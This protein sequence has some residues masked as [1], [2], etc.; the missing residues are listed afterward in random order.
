MVRS[1]I[2][3]SPHIFILI[4]SSQKFNFYYLY[5]SKSTYK[6]K[7]KKFYDE[8]N[9]SHY[10]EH[11]VITNMKFSSYHIHMCCLLYHFFNFTSLQV[12]YTV[13]FQLIYMHIFNK[14]IF[15]QK[16]LKN[17]KSCKEFLC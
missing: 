1:N 4:L 17:I 3:T 14:K 2:G 9:F 8:K 13:L 16:S 11:K 5:V 6:M 10:E 7:Q 12:F 15:G